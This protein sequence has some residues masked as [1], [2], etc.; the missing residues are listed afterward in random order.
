MLVVKT[1]RD[2]STFKKQCPSRL[3]TLAKARHLSHWSGSRS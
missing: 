1:Y 2:W 3:H